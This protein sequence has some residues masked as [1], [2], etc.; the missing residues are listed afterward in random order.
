[1]ELATLYPFINRS[2]VKKLKKRHIP[3]IYGLL[4]LL[5][6]CAAPKTSVPVGVYPK[7]KPTV[8]EP[9]ALA[10]SVPP[11]YKVEVFMKDLV[12]PTSIEFDDDGN[13]YVAEAGYAYGDPFAPAQVFRITRNG[14]ITRLS[15]KFLGPIT[16]LLYHEG[17]LFVSYKGKISL[18]TMDGTVTDLVTGLPSYG[19]HHN[20]QMTVGPEGKIYFGQGTVTNSGVVGLDNVYPYVWLMLWPDLHDVPAKDLKLRGESF[21]T[22]Q[23]NNVLARQGNLISLGSNL[24][25]AVGSIFSR[26]KD[27]SLLVRTRAFQ[28]FGEHKKEVKGNVKASGTIL[29]MNTDGTALEV[30]AWGL[31]N[32]FGVMWGPDGEL[33][34]ADNG[35]DERGSRPIANALDN[36]YK[37]RKDGWYGFP[38]FS[39]GI[40][41]THEQFQPKRGAKLKFLLKDHPPVEHPWLTRPENGGV[42]KLDFSKND[43]FGFKGHMFLTEV[44]SATPITGEDKEL[45]GYTVVRIDPSTKVVEPFL[46]NRSLGPKGMEYVTTAGPRRPVESKFSPDGEVLYIVDIGIISADLAGPGPFPIPIPGTGVI[47]RITKE[48]STFPTPSGNLSAMPP[49]A[50]K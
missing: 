22:P 3:F 10:A 28:P 42:T 7:D 38:D 30:F 19:D 4:L 23:P 15:D 17:K 37:I 21:L 34:V 36:I 48:G 40:P 16:D 11:G 6:G 18:L 45:K 44:G 24:T 5:I 32:P 33:Y 43:S 49:H 13:V 26:N 47:W 31:R 14:E 46:T 20:N 9:D 25:Y 1:M 50:S 29:R 27:K 41:V 12:W 39:S 2:I 35:Y 8:L